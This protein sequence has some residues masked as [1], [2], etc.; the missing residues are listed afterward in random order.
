MA[1]CILLSVNIIC[2]VFGLFACQSVRE[3]QVFTDNVEN[4]ESSLLNDLIQ[5]EDFDESTYYVD[6]IQFFQEDVEGETLE[7][8]SVWVVAFHLPEDEYFQVSHWLSLM[9][10]STSVNQ[11][12]YY[13]FKY[14]SGSFFEFEPALRNVDGIKCTR[15]PGGRFKE[16]LFFRK[17]DH[18]VSVFS[19][20][21]R[22][23]IKQDLLAVW[24][25]PFLDKLEER[26]A[27]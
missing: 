25:Q 5:P 26:M 3:V 1:R 16:C 6:N 22:D 10:R 2:L 9:D 13:I 23:H 17:Y 8:A 15:N 7:K 11:D 27:E 18:I 21:V 4:K 24:V 19:V 14:E 12:D 20:T